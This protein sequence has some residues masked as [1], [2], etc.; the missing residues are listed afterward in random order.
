MKSFFAHANNTL[1]KHW[2]KFKLQNSKNGRE[3]KNIIITYHFL[4]KKDH[5]IFE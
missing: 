1:K 5:L 2:L 3:K 4:K